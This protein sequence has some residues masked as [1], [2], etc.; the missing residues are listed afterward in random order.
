MSE[1]IL[2]IGYSYDGR[3]LAICYEIVGEDTIVQDVEVVKDEAE[4][5]EWF[6]K[7][8]MEQPWVERQ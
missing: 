6:A 5:R 1:S 7:V 3:M 8:S 2:K 4:A